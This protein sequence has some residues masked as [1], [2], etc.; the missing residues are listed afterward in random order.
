ML[1][2]LDKEKTGSWTLMDN[3]H[4]QSFDF[5]S[6]KTAPWTWASV[7]WAMSIICSK[8]AVKDMSQKT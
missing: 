7:P 6:A 8:A 3:E 2:I 4:E 1:V 5:F